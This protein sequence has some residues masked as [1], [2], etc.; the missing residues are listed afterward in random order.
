M[1]PV[2]SVVFFRYYVT[3]FGELRMR[4]TPEYL[5]L[6]VSAHRPGLAVVLVLHRIK[7]ISS[8]LIF[9]LAW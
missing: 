2:S 7:E 1:D 4:F 8:M 5:E 9:S 3:L 6:G